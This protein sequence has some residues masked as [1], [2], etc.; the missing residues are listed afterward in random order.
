MIVFCAADLI[1]AT[2]IKS[3]ADSLGISCRPVRNREMMVARL[4]DSPVRAL[5][6][7]L[8]AGETGL[9]LIRMVKVKGGIRVVVFGPHVDAEGFE[10]ARATG[11][12][13]VVARG[14]FGARLP[15]ILQALADDGSAV[16]DDLE[17]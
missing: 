14:A 6:V 2:R 12:D 1:W 17:E 15:Q 10:R 4:G 13:A 7:D 8:E 11:A 3:T 16:G 5:I 9:E